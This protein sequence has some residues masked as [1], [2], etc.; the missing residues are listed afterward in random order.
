[1]ARNV[2]DIV[3]KLST[4]KRKKVEARAARLIAGEMKPRKIQEIASHTSTNLG[5]P[6]MKDDG[7]TTLNKYSNKL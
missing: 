3:R 4:A 7:L 5:V 6:A 2:N 1:M